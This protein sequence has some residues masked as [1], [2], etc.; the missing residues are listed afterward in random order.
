MNLDAAYQKLDA[1][2]L[3][4]A[5]SVINASWPLPQEITSSLP[6]APVFDPALLPQPLAEFVMDEADRMNCPPDYIAAALMV[7]IGSV[8][9]TRCALKPKRYD[10]W[11]VPPN[12][13]GGIIGDPSSK[14]SPAAAA[15]IRFLNILEAKEAQKHEES[16]SAYAAEMAAYEAQQ[17][18][19]KG[20]MKR[21]ASGKK[22]HDQ[23]SAAIFELQSLQAPQEP[24]QRRFITN[25]STVAKLGD[26]L[27]NNPQGL[28]VHRDEL[29]G[30]LASWDREGNEG[31]RAFYLEAWNGTGS[32]T[33][34]RVARGSQYIPL[35]LLSV[36]GCIQPE[37]LERYLS[38]MAGSLDNDGR[39]QRFQMLVFPESI[40]WKWVDRYPVKEARD[41]VKSLFERLSYADFVELGAQPANDFI[42]MPHFQ[43]DNAALDLFVQWSDELNNV[44]I[45]SEDN[46]LMKQ[47]YGK[48]EKLF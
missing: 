41:Y 25:D 47:H 10:D 15:V 20:N 11:I 29:V 38:Q 4:H 2:D 42:K 46:P 16:M 19:I 28:L 37:L 44:L 21:V 12:L 32:F 27:A 1:L 7:C 5:P 30:L 31:D 17:T 45:T 22:A 34:D 14:K 9:G 43:F 39:F 35:L 48:Y 23:M 40:P 3:S 18:V 26:L 24:Q 8:V 6:A 36:F 13:Y 33:I